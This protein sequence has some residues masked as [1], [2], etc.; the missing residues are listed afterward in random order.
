MENEVK[1]VSD[2]DFIYSNMKHRNSKIKHLRDLFHS[3]NMRD[4]TCQSPVDFSKFNTIGLDRDLKYCESKTGE[5][6]D[7]GSKNLDQEVLLP[8]EQFV[9]V[10]PPGTVFGAPTESRELCCFCQR[11][12]HWNMSPRE[13]GNSWA[14]VLKNM[15]IENISPFPVCL[16]LFLRTTRYFITMSE[17][18]VHVYG[19]VSPPAAA[20]AAAPTPG[21][22]LEL[23]EMIGAKL[24]GS[25]EDREELRGV[26]AEILFDSATQNVWHPRVEVARREEGD[27]LLVTLQLRTAAGPDRDERHLPEINEEEGQPEGAADR[28]AVGPRIPSQRS[29]S[30]CEPA[31]AA[32][33]STQ[34]DGPDAR[35]ELELCEEKE[36]DKQEAE[37]V[38][39]NGTDKYLTKEMERRFFKKPKSRS[40]QDAPK[41]GE[42]RDVEDIPLKTA[43]TTQIDENRE[44][45]IESSFMFS[46]DSKLKC[47]EDCLQEQVDNVQS[48]EPTDETANHAVQELVDKDQSAV[49]KPITIIKR[50][51]A[52]DEDELGDVDLCMTVD[53]PSDEDYDSDASSDMRDADISVFCDVE[54]YSVE[55]PGHKLWDDMGVYERDDANGEDSNV[56]TVL[57]ENTNFSDKDLSSAIQS[58]FKNIKVYQNKNARPTKAKEK[59]KGCDKENSTD[60][61]HPGIPD[62]DPASPLANNVDVANVSCAPEDASRIDYVPK[63]ERCQ[64]RTDGDRSSDG[65]ERSDSLRKQ[66]LKLRQMDPTVELDSDNVYV[67]FNKKLVPAPAGDMSGDPTYCCGLCGEKFRS[68]KDLVSHAR[69]HRESRVVNVTVLA[70]GARKKKSAGKCKDCGRPT[71]AGGECT[72]APQSLCDVCGK[73]FHGWRRLWSHYKSQH[74]LRPKRPGLCHRCG[75]TFSGT[76]TLRRHVESRHGGAASRRRFVCDHCGKAFTTKHQI[77][78]HI[79]IHLGLKPFE[80]V[81]CGMRFGVKMRWREHMYLHSGAKP[82]S[83]DACGQ[84]FRHMSA[85]S[86]H[87]KMHRLGKI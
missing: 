86:L 69:A 12:Q 8:L 27:L 5:Q 28:D 31:E 17:V 74:R 26:V 16:K 84:D 32:N 6:N 4:V 41:Q 10:M 75:E 62:R 9:F 30:G 53:A 45:S 2:G 43:G 48:R 33:G 23:E 72:G 35:D 49:S 67:L 73:L 40:I 61:Q 37:D 14:D 65:D 22:V 39:S 1:H 58:R 55:S 34:M 77:A 57:S 25:R 59:R 44:G 38:P 52:K 24:D 80:C 66:K 42:T 36:S 50:V 7:I 83:C 87:K 11:I 76:G 18:G 21:E 81:A 29:E 68:Y 56:A 47:E 46:S 71:A 15:A 19:A 79:K 20:A 13:G 64:R 85:L 51:F 54:M 78:R 3:E 70:P 63:P 82:Y 60:T